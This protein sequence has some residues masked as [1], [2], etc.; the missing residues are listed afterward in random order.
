MTQIVF[1][2]IL[3]F[4]FLD[5]FPGGPYPKRRQGRATA[6]LSAYP[7]IWTKD[8]ANVT[9][10]SPSPDNLRRYFIE[11]NELKKHFLKF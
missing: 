1:N 11:M 2:S 7:K 4:V 6:T 9:Q 8:C 10:K 5:F 3:F